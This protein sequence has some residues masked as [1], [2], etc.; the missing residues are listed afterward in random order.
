VARGL[1]CSEYFGLPCQVSF[2]QLLHPH[3][4]S[5]KDGTIDQ[6][7]VD[8]PS[9]LSLTPPQETKTKTRLRQRNAPV[10]EYK[11]LGIIISPS[12]EQNSLFRN[13][14]KHLQSTRKTIPL[15]S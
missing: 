2:H 14:T 7:V 9:G 8:V 4:L 3:H 13:S 15:R 1:V 10:T 11:R 6:L 5:P 12:K